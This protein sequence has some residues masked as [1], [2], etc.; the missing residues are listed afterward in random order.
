VEEAGWVWLG[1]EI[2]TLQAVTYH[3]RGDTTKALAVLERALTL[4]KPEGFVRLFLDCGPPMGELLQ[5]AAARGIVPDY[6]DKLL[7][8]FFTGAEPGPPEFSTNL[9]TALAEPLS[10]RELEVLRLIAAGL[11]NR[12]IAEEL[13]V[14][15][16]TVKTH[17][18]NIYGKLDVSSRTQSLVKARELKLI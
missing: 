8:A 12:E 16:S 17:V 5:Q 4:A 3:R 13:V 6:V 7:A 1:I 10:Q 2:L 14:A 11:S 18:R 9:T 15:I